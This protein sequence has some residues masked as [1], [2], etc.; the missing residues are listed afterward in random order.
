MLGTA[1]DVLTPLSN[2]TREIQ[3]TDLLRDGT[4]VVNP[5]LR[6]IVVIVRYQVNGG[7]QNYRLT[8]Y[9]SSFS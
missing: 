6:Q 1:D 4:A 2:F 8:T 3:I 7:W 5:N 9:V